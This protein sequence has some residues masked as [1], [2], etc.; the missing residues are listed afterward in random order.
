M[1]FNVKLGLFFKFGSYIILFSEKKQQL[2]AE[3]LSTQ[4]SQAIKKG[5][6]LCKMVSMKKV[7]KYRWQPRNGCDG[8]PLTKILITTI[9]VNFLPIPIL[10]KLG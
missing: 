5:A 9:Q 3:Y 8:R 1:Y 10:V 4:N 6:A 7:V 2:P